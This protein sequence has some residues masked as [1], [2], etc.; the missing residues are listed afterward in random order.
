MN[1]RPKH[2]D[3]G[4]LGGSLPMTS[5]IDVVFLLLVFFLVTSSF[6]LSEEH[7]SAAAK[8]ERKGQ[9]STELTP[10]IID[11]VRRDGRDL[12]LLG[13]TATPSQDALTKLLRTL[14]KDPGVAVR[15]HDD[16][17]V[18]AAA[19]ALQAAENA[20]FTKRSYVPAASP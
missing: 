16:A 19:S 9:S 5:M 17:T 18:Q 2:K 3:I 6:A 4:D 10:Q 14:P 11:V 15:V 20:G 12:F 7:L 13:E 8:S 1:F